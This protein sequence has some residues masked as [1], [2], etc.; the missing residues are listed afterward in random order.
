MVNGDLGDL[1]NLVAKLV[2]GDLKVVLEPA[3]ILR[4]LLEEVLVLEAMLLPNLVIQIIVV[5]TFI[6]K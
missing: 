3:L 2:V 4:L 1:G 6:S 5:S